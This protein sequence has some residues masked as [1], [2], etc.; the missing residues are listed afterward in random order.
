MVSLGPFF[1]LFFLFLPCL[2]RCPGIGKP[3]RG[4]QHKLAEG[5]KLHG[6]VSPHLARDFQPTELTTLRQSAPFSLLPQAVGV[7]ALVAS[8]KGV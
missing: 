7:S 6:L 4:E 3:T 5:P 2:Y 8:S 1:F